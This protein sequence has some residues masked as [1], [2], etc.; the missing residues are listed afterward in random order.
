MADS[1]GSDFYCIDDL[2][3]NLSVVEER[4]CLAQA[5]VRRISTPKYGLFY[6]GDYGYDV[7]QELGKPQG[8]PNRLSASRIETQVLM[9]ERVNNS[10]AEVEFV[11]VAD[12]PDESDDSLNITISITDDDGPFELVTTIGS[13]GVTL[14]LLQ[15]NT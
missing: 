13:D 8:Q 5:S 10:A 7:R 15:D 11:S 12:S 1:L 2:D 9:D 4:D 3:P 14:E 6:D